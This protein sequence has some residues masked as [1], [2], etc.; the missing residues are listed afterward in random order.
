MVKRTGITWDNAVNIQND[1]SKISEFLKAS[2]G[3]WYSDFKQ[4]STV[5]TA[6]TVTTFD[7]NTSFDNITITF[8]QG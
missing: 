2:P 1:T 4:I 3:I 6:T 7:S 5:T 8:D